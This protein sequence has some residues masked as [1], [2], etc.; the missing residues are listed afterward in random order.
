MKSLLNRKVK[1]DLLL[2]N[3][4]AYLDYGKSE[5]DEINE[6]SEIYRSTFEK[7]GFTVLESRSFY[8]TSQYFHRLIQLSAY[9][10]VSDI[11]KA[12]DTTLACLES[13]ATTAELLY[14]AAQIVDVE[15]LKSDLVICGQDESPIYRYGLPILKKLCGHIAN[16]AY[17]PVCPGIH[18]SEMHASDPDSNKI[19]L[20][21]NKDKIHRK[22]FRH[23]K[24]SDGK[25]DFIDYCLDFLFPL[26]GLQTQVIIIRTVLKSGSLDKL[27]YLLTENLISVIN[28]CQSRCRRL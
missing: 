8:P 15:F 28:A 22:V 5:W 18:R 25:S 1:C 2:A 23:A 10:K 4:H 6:R 21:D 13:D 9:F 27:A 3:Y 11:L 7:M 16:Y 24:F 17:L 19:L 12:G 26:A 20:D 14:T